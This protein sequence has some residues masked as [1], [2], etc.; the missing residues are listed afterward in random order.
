MISILIPTYNNEKSINILINSLEE[1]LAL[2]KIKYEIMLIDD[3][4]VIPIKKIVEN[5]P[6]IIIHQHIKNYGQLPAIYTGLH[7]MNGDACIIMSADLQ[8]SVSVIPEILMKWEEGHDFVIGLR[9]K[10]E[11]NIFS[12]VFYFVI[13]LFSK[14]KLPFNGYDFGLLDKSLIDKVKNFNP[15][16]SFLQILLLEH[17]TNLSYVKYE[18]QK[19]FNK[20]S[21]W[22]LTHKIFYALLA[23]RQLDKFFFYKLMIGA[24]LLT[25]ILFYKDLFIL[26]AISGLSF[27][28]SLYIQLKIRSLK[29]RKNPLLN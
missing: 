6:S 7:K 5:K 28:G 13:N 17:C 2:V 25:T 24:L 11:F 29:K 22:S 19:S 4:S 10:R 8:E 15:H 23:F 14:S 26:S 1:Q 18:R 9:T 3:G 21:S 12:S 16:I 27:S 20:K